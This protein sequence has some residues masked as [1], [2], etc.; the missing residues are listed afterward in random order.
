MRD[1]IYK[2]DL[3]AGPMK[4][5]MLGAMKDGVLTGCDQSHYVTGSYTRKGARVSG[6]FNF[7]RHS[8]RDDF[9]E[10]A[11]L[12]DFTVQFSGI[13]GESFGQFESVV[14]GRPGLIVKATFRWLCE[15]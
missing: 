8:S 1:G 6:V 11:Y 13:C 9:K 10:I 15:A 5:L 3:S 4:G 2:V 12:D 14:P 7:K